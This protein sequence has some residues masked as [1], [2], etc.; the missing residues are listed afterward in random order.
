MLDIKTLELTVYSSQIDLAGS[1][2]IVT[3][4]IIK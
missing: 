4:I 1:Y 2:L 3:I